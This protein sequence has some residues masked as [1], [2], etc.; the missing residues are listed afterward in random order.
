MPGLLAAMV[1]VIAGSNTTD[2]PHNAV[3]TLYQ[4]ATA[5]ADLAVRIVST[6]GAVP[7]LSQTVAQCSDG[8]EARFAAEVFAEAAV[9]GAQHADA[10]A[11]PD[12]LAALVSAT[13]RT[14]MGVPC[15]GALANLSFASRPLALRVADTP[16]AEAVM[17]AALT[18]SDLK[19]AINATVALASI[20]RADGGRVARLLSA[21]RPG[22]RAPGAVLGSSQDQPHD[23]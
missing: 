11:T 20:A 23:G 13:S 12:V 21:R 6:P 9:A 4:V 3:L 5:G 1:G 19:A 7:A 10:I 17:L 8:L 2:A 16:G 14:D 22:R 18:S 15:M